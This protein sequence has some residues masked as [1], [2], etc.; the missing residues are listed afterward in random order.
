MVG[1]CSNIVTHFKLNRVPNF[2]LFQMLDVEWKPE[3]KK[4]AKAFK[5][6]QHSALKECTPICYGFWYVV[7]KTSIATLFPW[8]LWKTFIRNIN[9]ISNGTL[10]T[11]SQVATTTQKRDTHLSVSRS[12]VPHSCSV[13]DISTPR[14]QSFGEIYVDR[15]L[16][17]SSTEF[18]NLLTLA[19]K[20]TWRL[21]T[22][23][24]ANFLW[25]G[26]DWPCKIMRAIWLDG[27]K[28]IMLI[29]LFFY[30]YII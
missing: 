4:R 18:R 2:V 24:F 27:A 12:L 7:K 6:Q 28:I 19:R 14:T 9:V 8:F 22:V 1:T 16:S 13:L 21:Y 30:F 15:T 23:T 11:A 5:L 29:K 20:L 10:V 3:Q 26:S 17:H 25:A